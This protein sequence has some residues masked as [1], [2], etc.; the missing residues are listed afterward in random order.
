MTRAMNGPTSGA[1]STDNGRERRLAI[2]DDSLIR[3][4]FKEAARALRGESAAPNLGAETVPEF[5]FAGVARRCTAG[6]E[7]SWTSFSAS[8]EIKGRSVILGVS[9]RTTGRAYRADGR[10]RDLRNLARKP[11]LLERACRD[12]GLELSTEANPCLMRYF[13]LVEAILRAGQ[14]TSGETQKP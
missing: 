10:T 13:A 7:L 14:P 5:G 6:S 8:S 11:A 3:G 9:S 1:A 2:S 4:E 12:K